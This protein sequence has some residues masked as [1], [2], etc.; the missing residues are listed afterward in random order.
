MPS[1]PRSRR[2]G[3]M[4]AVPSRPEE[5]A[6]HSG[7][8]LRPV[9]HSPPEA[10]PA[11]PPRLRGGKLFLSP[12]LK[13]GGGWGIRNYSTKWLLSRA[14]PSVAPRIEGG[15]GRLTRGTSGKG[16]RERPAPAH[17]R[18]AA[19]AAAGLRAA[20]SARQ[21]SGSLATAYRTTTAGATARDVPP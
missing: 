13:R 12:T 6:C 15:S 5:A 19:G 2:H 20:V 4:A 11:L 14:R 18:E 9:C 1:S 17:P 3:A 8:L 16:G 21:S 10:A 7:A